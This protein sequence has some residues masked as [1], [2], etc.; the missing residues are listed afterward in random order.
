[1]V[2]DFASWYAARDL[3]TSLSLLMKVR[4]RRPRLQIGMFLVEMAALLLM[5][6]VGL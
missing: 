1:M 6:K 5:T 3:E 4:S 2:G